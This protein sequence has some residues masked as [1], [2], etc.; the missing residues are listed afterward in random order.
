LLDTS[1]SNDQKDLAL[2]VKSSAKSLLVIINDVLDFSKSEAGKLQLSPVAFDLRKCIEEIEA[3]LGIRMDQKGLQFVAGI[4]SD[5]PDRVFGDPDRLRQVLINLIGNSIKFTERE[6][7]ITLFVELEDRVADSVLLQFNVTDSG[8]GIPEDKQK[9][10]FEAF[11]QADASTT[12]Q[13]GGTGLGLSIAS[14]LVGLM[15]GN[16]GLNSEPG[17]GSNFHFTARFDVIA[18]EQEQEQEQQTTESITFARPLQILLAEDNVVNQKLVVRILEKVGL[19]V[20]VAQNGTE[21]VE[22]SEAQDFDI[23]LMDIQM[24]VMGGIEATSVI[25]EKE[26]ASGSHIPIIALTANAMAG[27]KKQYLS[28]GMDAYVSKPFRKHELLSTIQK[29]VSFREDVC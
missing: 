14:Q 7:G 3:I 23:I 10:I 9:R 15:G 18:E 1:L 24:P 17:K 19:K 26:R 29:L 16:I 21:A 27:D 22:L 28:C 2:T 6:G 20:T 5:V 11:S 13:F 4:E 25:R 8:I 12:R